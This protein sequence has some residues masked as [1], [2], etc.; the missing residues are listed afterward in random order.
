MDLQAVEKLGL[1]TSFATPIVQQICAQLSQLANR[2][3]LT[4]DRNDYT[5]QNIALIHDRPSGLTG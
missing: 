2:F 4:L 3:R 5:M 1:A